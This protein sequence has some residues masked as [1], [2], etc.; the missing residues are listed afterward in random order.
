MP[1]ADP[2]V[3]AALVRARSAFACWADRHPSERRHSLLALRRAVVTAADHIADVVTAETGKPR[4]DVMMAEVLHAASHADWLARR[5]HRVLEGRSVWPWP[6]L[7]KRAWV[8]YRP[9]GVA[10][11]LTPWNYPF[12]LPF[13]GAATAVAAGCA[14]VVKPSELTPRSAALIAELAVAAGLPED[15][16][17]VIPGD[18]ARGAALV[19]SGVD[20]VSVTGSRQ[21]GKAVL[22]AAANTLIPVISELGGNNAMLV[23]ADADL[24]RAARGAVWGAFFNAG[25]SCV[26]VERCYVVTDVYH[27]FLAELDRALADVAA[28]T[29][30]RRDIGPMIDPRRTDV[31]R[32]QIADALTAGATLRAGG[33]VVWHA[34]HTYVEPTVLT[35]VPPDAQVL[36][37]ETFGPLLTL[38]EVPDEETALRYANDTSYGLHPSIWT[39]DRAHGQELARRLR[40]GAVAINDCLVNYALPGMPFGGVG[41]SGYG[42]QGGTEGLLAYCATLSVTDSW[43]RPRRELQWFPRVG[44]A[45]FWR[46]ISRC[47]YGR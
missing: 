35:D 17:Q 14:V 12:L 46:F 4:A 34:G 24:R 23:L 28:A 21:T 20:V 3:T 27:A 45:G 33:R 8:A 15:L 7:S 43:F 18:A 1:E 26:S 29:G 47:L 39:A 19:T 42:R 9:L 36:R 13:L 11:V 16:V 38:I 41:S 2:A 22:A 10:A 31:V 6:V 40:G 30:D 44:S 32:R 5:A 25:Q 37:E